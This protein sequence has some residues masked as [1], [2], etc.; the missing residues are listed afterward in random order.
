MYDIGKII[1]MENNTGKLPALPLS[2]LYIVGT[3]S[4]TD[5]EHSQKT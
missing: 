3:A 2:F 5:I 1:A 4:S